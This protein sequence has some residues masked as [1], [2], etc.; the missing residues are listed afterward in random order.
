MGNQDA[1]APSAGVVDDTNDF[2]DDIEVILAELRSMPHQIISSSSTTNN[3]AWISLREG[4]RKEFVS[5]VLVTRRVILGEDTEVEPKGDIVIC[6]APP[7]EAE[8]LQADYNQEDDPEQP[9]D[10]QQEEQQQQ[11]SPNNRVSCAICLVEYQPNDAICWSHNPK[12][13]HHYHQHCIHQWLTMASN[14]QPQLLQDQFRND[15]PC[16]RHNYLALSD[17]DDT[18]VSENDNADPEELVPSL[19]QLVDS[20]ES[21][22][23]TLERSNTETR[24][25]ELAAWGDGEGNDSSSLDQS[26]EYVEPLNEDDWSC[27]GESSSDTEADNNI[28]LS[29]TSRPWNLDLARRNRAASHPWRRDY[30]A[31]QRRSIQSPQSMPP[32]LVDLDLGTLLAEECLLRAERGEDDGSSTM[33]SGSVY[34]HH[35]QD[36]G[37]TQV[38]STPQRM[39]EE[40]SESLSLEKQTGSPRSGVHCAI[41]RNGYQVNE[42]LCWSRD[43]L[44]NHVFHRQCLDRW[45]LEA[46]DH[47]HCPLC[48]CEE[49]DI[50]IASDHGQ[51]L[52]GNSIGSSLEVVDILDEEQNENAE[53]QPV[54]RV[55]STPSSAHL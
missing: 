10:P 45:I 52:K 18:V 51:Q 6:R 22:V 31:R 34:T 17:D 5:N 54:S 27:P 44:C 20:M 26:L 41:C 11:Q 43:P 35:S 24:L 12:C 37:C 53:E 3:D 40:R 23:R 13:S 9:Q 28:Y 1:Y 14:Q 49:D 8:Q 16:C 36:Q 4:V 46:D 25:A 50:T 30:E 55:L 39:N 47:N 7:S 33:S 2:E 38:A 19:Q 42:E 29:S 32:Q 48:C 21:L 15:C